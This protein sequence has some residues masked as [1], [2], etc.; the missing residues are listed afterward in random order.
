MKIMPVAAAISVFF[1]NLNLVQANQSV[2]KLNV[3]INCRP[4]D[5][6]VYTLG[7]GTSR[8]IIPESGRAYYT[9]RGQN[10]IVKDTLCQSG[11]N[12][13]VVAFRSD[14]TVWAYVWA[15]DQ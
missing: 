9:F 5:P 4:P 7:W 6:G 3:N 14:G 12:S 11:D 15:T 10:T 1:L 8:L 13:G 2:V